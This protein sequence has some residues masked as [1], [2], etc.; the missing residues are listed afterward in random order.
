M[1]LFE[2]IFSDNN[3]KDNN[4][5]GFVTG[6][7]KE[8]YDE[9]Y[10]GMIKAEIFMTDGTVNVTDWM[11]VI[12]PYAGANKGMY[13]LPDIGD[14]VAIVFERGEIERPYVI[15]C[16]W[17]KVDT[18]PE[19]TVTQENTIKKLRTKGGHEI[20]F[21]DT[22][23]K[24]KI[25]IITTKKNKISMDDENSL[26]TITTSG[27]DG[28]NIIKIDSKGGIITL[29]AKKKIMLDAEGTKITI[30]K[31]AKKIAL[32]ADNI[33]LEGKTIKIKGQSV[34]IEGSTTD[35]KAAGTMNV[36]SDGATNIKGAMVKI[37]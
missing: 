5:S 30:D 18:I 1:E 19:S 31:E 21:D 36:K 10:P 32:E 8:I 11:R 17:N 37:N 13:F 25:D 6:I 34:S 12:V 23:D 16:L 15:G 29:D 9:K 22:K 4:L 14:E 27:D 24:G 28:D 3:L 35:I 33:N 26:I 2:N 7:V 20:I